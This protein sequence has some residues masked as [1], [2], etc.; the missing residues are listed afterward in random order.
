[1]PIYRSLPNLLIIAIVL[2]FGNSRAAS[3]IELP[4][5]ETLMT[6]YNL[7]SQNVTVIEPHES[8]QDYAVMVSYKALP[9]TD[10]L[11]KWFGDSWKLPGTEI[12]F[13]AQ[14]GYRSVVNRDKLTKYRAF[15][16][17][18]RTD[19][20]PFVVD[21]I[22]QTQYKI[23]LGPYYLIW[24]NRGNQELLSQG[25]YGWP[26]QIKVIELLETSGSQRL[27]PQK[28]SYYLEQ[29][30]SDTKTYCLTYH[31]VRGVGGNKY[32]IDLLQAACRWTDTD[33][34]AMIESPRRYNSNPTMPPLGRMLPANE[35]RLIIERIVNYLNVMQ[36]E[37]RQSCVKK[38]IPD[39]SVK[40]KP[41]G[42][43]N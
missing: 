23:P 43:I 8:K 38:A 22:G 37:Q 5:P 28:Q 3:A 21:N 9:M 6:K 19:G 13:L 7:K 10:L 17:F 32:P 40:P 39:T 2:A 31:H 34:K 29:G 41:K 20:L 4:A 25:A 12:V 14:D 15:L 42:L 27:Q 11:T 26:Y 24:E 33:L 16:A 30:L 36:T 1:M 35:R 18:A